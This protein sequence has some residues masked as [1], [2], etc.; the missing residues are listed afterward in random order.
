MPWIHTIF[1]CKWSQPKKKLCSVDI[2]KLS[3]VNQGRE[4]NL[5]LTS[6]YYLLEKE[7]VLL[8]FLNENVFKARI[9]S[10]GSSNMIVAKLH[11]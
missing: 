8:V 5:L 11:D 4:I 3:K 9:K 2:P 7:Y 10:Q 6:E 1:H